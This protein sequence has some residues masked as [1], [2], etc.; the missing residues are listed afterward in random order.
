MGSQISLCKFHK[1]SLN[2]RLLEGKAVTLWDELTEHKAVYQKA[3]FQFLM[4]D[5]SFSPYPSMGFQISLWKFHKN[6]LSERLLEGKAV[7]LRWNK[8][9]QNSFSERFIPVFHIRY[10]LFQQSAL[11]AYKYHFPDSTRQPWRKSSWRE[12]CNSVRWI[13]RRQSSFWENFFP[14]FNWRYFLFHLTLYGL[15]NVTFQIPQEQS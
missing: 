3:S 4:E 10:F 12:N 7:T 15:P 6:S 2:E 11:W 1:N 9:A 8:R 5:I 13:K 14:V